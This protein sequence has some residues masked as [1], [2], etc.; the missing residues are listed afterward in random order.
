M[1][2]RDSFSGVTN[3]G[4]VW[5]KSRCRKGRLGVCPTPCPADEKETSPIISTLEVQHSLMETLRKLQRDG[6][7][8]SF[9]E[10]I[11]L[12]CQCELNS[13]QKTTKSNTDRQTDR[14]THT[15][16]FTHSHTQTQTDRQTDRQTDT[17]THMRARAQTHTH[18]HIHT[19]THLH[20]HTHI[21][22]KNKTTT[23][24]NKQQKTNEI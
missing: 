3:Y 22:T 5:R 12:N 1:C 24:K 8:V 2:I 4:K 15:H 11:E 9:R 17:H 21:Y 16:T 14:H 23:T 13:L 10:R 6:K 18:T 20:T 7:S 19:H